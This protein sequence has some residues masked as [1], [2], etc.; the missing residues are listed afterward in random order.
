MLNYSFMRYAFIV[1]IMLSI[2]IPLV[3]QTAVLKRLSTKG[4]AL[5]HTALLGVAIGLVSG[6]NP[7]VIAII[8]CIIASLV[9]EFIRRKFNKYSELSVAIVMSASIAFAA[10]ISNFASGNSFSSYLFG[11]ILLIRNVELI[12]TIIIFI[13]TIVFYIGFYHQIMYI[14]YNETQARLDGVKVNLINLVETILTAIII[15]IASKII[16]ALMVSALMVI[17]YA[18]SMQL[19]KSYK[20]SM[21]ISCIISLLSVVL[22]LIIS[23]YADFQPGGTI[24]VIAVISLIITMI[25]NHIFRFTS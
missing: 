9:I 22:G 23:Y 12:F 19:T 11:S 16:G 1:G 21:I 20:R 17:P 13:V 25:L 5:S 18:A 2:I 15:A 3:G 14:T 10:I 6:A 4:D 7:L 8:T 24:V